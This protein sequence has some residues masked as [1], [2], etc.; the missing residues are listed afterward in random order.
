MFLEVS[1]ETLSRRKPAHSYI[2]KVIA[3]IFVVLICILQ[4]RIWWGESGYT[5]IKQLKKQLIEQKQDNESLRTQ[6][7]ILK[8]EIQALRNN[9]DSL[10]E[11]AREQLGL[12]KPGET[13]YRIIPSDNN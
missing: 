11:L 1:G 5:E 8:K 3:A 6:N 9:P 2:M 4:Y 7:E 12:I 13:F 10:E